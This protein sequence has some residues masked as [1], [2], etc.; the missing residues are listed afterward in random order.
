MLKMLNTILSILLLSATVYA[1]FYYE[2]DIVNNLGYYAILLTSL[3]SL[4]GFLSHIIRLYADISVNSING[5]ADYPLISLAASFI[6]SLFIAASGAVYLAAFY[7]VS[8]TFFN[9]FSYILK[10]AK[11]EIDNA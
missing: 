6:A 3:L 2:Y 9:L 7:M 8:M 10:T 11:Q 4:F 5:I 1:G